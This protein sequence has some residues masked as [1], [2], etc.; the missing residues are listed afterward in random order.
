MQNVLLYPL[1][2][3]SLIDV[4]I[5]YCHCIYDELWEDMRDRKG[6]G[7]TLCL[8]KVGIMV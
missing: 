2:R 4:S 8:M 1:F 7:G 3:K 6:F 5:C